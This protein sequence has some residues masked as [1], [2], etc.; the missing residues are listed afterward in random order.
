MKEHVA[1]LRK[2][3]L[4]LPRLTKNPVVT[5]HNEKRASLALADEV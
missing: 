3:K 4:P 2:R 5:I 1:L